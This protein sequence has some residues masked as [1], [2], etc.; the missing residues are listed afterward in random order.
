MG[1]ITAFV[2]QA[3]NRAAD[4]APAE[5]QA[6]HLSPDAEAAS[7]E[8]LDRPAG[9]NERLAKALQRL[10]KFSADANQNVVCYD[11][12]PMTSVDR[13]PERDTTV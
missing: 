13:T 8:A 1:N 5:R 7:T 3:A 2:L 10:A 4:D 9:V 12:L 6:A 11:S